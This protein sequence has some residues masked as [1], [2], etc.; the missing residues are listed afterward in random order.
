MI[1]RAVSKNSVCT[2]LCL[3]VFLPLTTR[4]LYA[5]G[6]TLPRGQL[7]AKLETV[8]ESADR[9]YD[10][11]GET[12]PIGT[13]VAVDEITSQATTLFLAY[14]LSP[15]LTVTAAG[16]L[17]ETDLEFANGIT[18]SDDGLSDLWLGAYFRLAQ[19]RSLSWVLGARAEL[20]QQENRAATPQITNGEDATDLSLGAGYGAATYY[21]EGVVSRRLENGFVNNAVL[22]GI[23]YEDSWSATLKAGWQP[24]ARWDLEGTIS[25]KRTDA[26]LARESYIPG[27]FANADEDRLRVSAGYRLTERVTLGAVVDRVFAGKNLLEN[28]LLGLQLVLAWPR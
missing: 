3:L 28:E 24:A 7:Y 9:A 2:L 15:R 4:D 21:L 23:P 16:Q 22:G 19:W 10:N 14:G 11:R 20:A 1:Y 5:G 26:D 27:I 18:R 17:R 6:F 25:L 13:D 12:R 8:S